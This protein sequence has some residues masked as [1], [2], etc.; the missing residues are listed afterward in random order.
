ML[1]AVAT[2]IAI[3]LVFVYAQAV[4]LALFGAIVLGEAARPSV[5]RL[6]A[7]MPRGLAIV[8][9]FGAAS[10]LLA[11]VWFIPIRLIAPSLVA[12]VG[13]LPAY[14]KGA[15]SSVQHL[16]RNADFSA[17]AAPLLKFIFG[18]QA[19]VGALL[20]TVALT[21]V[22]SI[23]WMTSSLSLHAFLE[24]L[25][26][27]SKRV[28][29][30]AV[31]LELSDKLGMY[32]RGTIMNGTFVAAICTA[33]LCWMQAPYPVALGVLQGLLVAIPYLGTFI[34]VLMVGA[35]VFAAQG[36]AR[37]AEGV[38]LVSLAQTLVGTFISPLIFKKRVDV[39]P[40]SVLLGTAIGG[41]LFGIGGIILAVPGVAVLQTLSVRCLAPAIRATFPDP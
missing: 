26:P 16:F 38:L 7:H 35:I 2:V 23:F 21:L 18:L 28:S 17:A 15:T 20:S 19:G 6:S 40:L 27:L 22:M 1:A 14:L 12:L 11:V 10:L 25:L 13:A 39:D 8:L 29:V 9:V 33:L 24:S 3:S 31:L 4:V 37:A 41:A 30:N 36:W 32:V 34:G 5:K